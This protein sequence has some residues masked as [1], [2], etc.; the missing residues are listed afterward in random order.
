MYKKIIFLI[1]LLI[2]TLSSFQAFSQDKSLKIYVPKAP[3]SIP[4]LKLEQKGYDID[5]I[6]YNDVTTEILPRILKNEKALYIIPTNV[7][8]KLYNKGKNIRQLSIASMGIVKIISTDPSA[9]KISDLDGKEI[10]IP[11]PG[12]SPDVIARFL[13]SRNKVS[14]AIKYGSTPEIT[15]LLLAG[16][17]RS[18]VLPE[19]MASLVLTKKTDARMISDTKSDW[20]AAV[21]GSGGIPQVGICGEGSY[22]SKMS[23]QI[24]LFLKDYGRAVKEVNANPGDAAAE[25]RNRLEIALPAAVLAK[26]VPEMNLVNITGDDAYEELV[27][28]FRVLL[29]MDSSS[30]GDKIPDGN[31]VIR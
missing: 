4:L 13:F 24:K 10:H 28:Y 27:I 30:L 9:S 14:P 23:G 3:P 17:I 6:Y 21:K 26:S 15:Q 5:I 7:S 22:I 29:E 25:G 20:A 11:A 31:F 19:P 18:A 16:K 12:S 2:L 8:A 1:A